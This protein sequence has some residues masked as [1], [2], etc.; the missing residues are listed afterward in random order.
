M[1]QW[2]PDEDAILIRGR[3]RGRT[4]AMIATALPRRSRL[5]CIARFDELQKR[6]DWRLEDPM[7]LRGRTLLGLG[8]SNMNRSRRLG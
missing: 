2:T 3:A 4:Y 5:A 6:N 7:D 8:I 1:R